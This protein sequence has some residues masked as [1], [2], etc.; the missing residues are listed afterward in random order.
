[1][2]EVS[3]FFKFTFFVVCFSTKSYEGLL[4]V[5]RAGIVKSKILFSRIFHFWTGD[6][7]EVLNNGAD[8][9]ISICEEITKQG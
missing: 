2:T 7:E 9:V 1:M 8:W 4:S 3:I 5:G 6:V